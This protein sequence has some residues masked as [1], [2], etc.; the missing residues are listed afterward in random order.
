MIREKKDDLF[1]ESL[2]I[3]YEAL[4]IDPSNEELLKQHLYFICKI[5]KSKRNF[6]DAISFASKALQIDPQFVPA[7]CER[8]QCYLDSELYHKALNDYEEVLK[9]DLVQFDR[10]LIEHRWEKLC[11]IL[12]K[13]AI[14]SDNLDDLEPE[15]VQELRALIRNISN[16]EI[17]AAKKTDKHQ[18]NV[19]KSERD[20]FQ[21]LLESDGKELKSFRDLIRVFN[22][23]VDDGSPHYNFEFS[24]LT[25]N[26]P[27]TK[28]DKVKKH[29]DL[30]A[31]RP[32]TKSESEIVAEEWNAAGWRS[33]QGKC[34]R[35]AIANFS[36]AIAL[37][38]SA[39]FFANRSECYTALGDYESAMKDAL[40][41]VKSDSFNWR[42]YTV[43][44]NCCVTLGDIK[45]AEFLLKMF[46]NNV[47]DVESINFNEIPKLQA[48]KHFDAE[49]S[50]LFEE[51]CFDEC[52][53]LARKALR[54]AK[55]CIKFKEVVVMCLILLC[56]FSEAEEKISAIIENANEANIAYLQGLNFYHQYKF[57]ESIESFGRA[58]DD[59]SYGKEACNHI[60]K[61]IKMSECNFR[62]G[63][64]FFD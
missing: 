58:L 12:T 29:F 15:K 48:L 55:A 34:F 36:Q 49:I 28:T 19:A 61:A 43:A 57:E 24:M 59:G 14:S 25:C 44:I 56:E 38:P 35:E 46:Q 50:R 3:R 26:R 39:V 1:P 5:H 31:T 60:A 47:V 37:S 51:N 18:L 52:L 27:A 6:K 22:S 64:F 7:L 10:G 16:K 32:K 17:E 62:S 23:L 9:C 30:K 40:E 21:K 63:D 33:Y 2:Q 45:Q 13:E 42:S 41:S 8:A 54:L 20:A 11:G 53:K 4:N